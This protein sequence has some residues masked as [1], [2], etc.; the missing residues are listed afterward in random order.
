MSYF[1]F[2]CVVSNPI[3]IVFLLHFIFVFCF[4]AIGPFPFQHSQGPFWAYFQAQLRPTELPTAAVQPG[5][6]LPRI[7][8]PRCMTFLFSCMAPACLFLSRVRSLLP[9]DESWQMRWEWRR[10]SKQSTC[11]GQTGSPSYNWWTQ[12]IIT[13]PSFINRFAHANRHPCY[14]PCGCCESVGKWVWSV[15]FKGNHQGA[16]L[17]WRY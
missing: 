17:P 1:I 14:L 11:P 3:F 8:A 9:K 7:A 16:G 2:I 5:P 13:D 6:H 4:V 15:Y 12:W 10:P